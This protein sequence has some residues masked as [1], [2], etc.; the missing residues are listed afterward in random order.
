MKK[1]NSD[2]TDEQKLV[3]FEEDTE[4]PGSSILNNDGETWTCAFCEIE[5]ESTVEKHL[6]WQYGFVCP[7][8]FENAM[9]FD[10]EDEI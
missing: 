1:I 9:G 10:E 8:C 3:L 4:P 5:K 6:F 2:L 7:S